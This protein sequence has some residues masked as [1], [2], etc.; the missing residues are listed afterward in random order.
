MVKVKVIFVHTYLSTY[1]NFLDVTHKVPKSYLSKREKVSARYA[2][3]EEFLE[4]WP[5]LKTSL[6]PGW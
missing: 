1:I 4:A 2:M 3:I 6:V 5:I